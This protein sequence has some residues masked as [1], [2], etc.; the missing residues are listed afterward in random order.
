MDW[1]G[2]FLEVFRFDNFS[3]L[4]RAAGRTGAMGELG[5][6]ALRAIGYIGGGEEIVSPPHVFSRL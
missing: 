2:I 5:R 3:S 1:K 6:L 4:V